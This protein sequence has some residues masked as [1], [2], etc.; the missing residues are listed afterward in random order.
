MICLGA[1]LLSPSLE[2]APVQ[3]DYVAETWQTEA[4]LPHNSVTAVLQTRDGYL[5]LGT[6]NGLARFDGVRFSIFRAVDYAGLRSN[7]ILSLY[8][9]R[10]GVLWVG[11]AEGGL[12]R[13]DDGHF[14]AFSVSDGLSSDT[15]LSIG[16]GRSGELWVGTAS[17]LNRT[18]GARPTGAFQSEA[19]P[20]E[21]VFA[22]RL[23][24]RSPMLFATRKGLYQQRQDRVVP[25]A[26]PGSESRL[27]SI[28][29][30]L[31]EDAERRLWAGGET[32]LLRLDSSGQATTLPR[33]AI[34]DAAVRSLIEG[35]DGRIWMGTSVGDVY[36]VGPKTGPLEASLVGSFGGAIAALCED[37]EGNLWVGAAG[38]GLHRLKPRQVRWTPYPEDFGEPT[39]KTIFENQDGSLWLLTADHR[40]HRCQDTGLVPGEYLPLPDGAVV[41]TVCATTN[42]TLWLGTRSDGLWQWSDGVIRQFTER[43]G[44]SDSQVTVLCGDAA[45][46]LWIGT[47]NGGLNHLAD[48]KVTRFNTPWGFGGASACAL[49]LGPTGSLWIGTTGDGVFELS[50]G[51]FLAYTA[52]NGLPSGHAGALLADAVGALWIGTS[53]GLCRLLDGRITV[54][55]GPNRLTYEAILQLRADAEGHL[56]IG[57]STGLY[58]YRIDQLN[59]YADGKASFVDLVPLGKEDGLPGIQCVSRNQSRSW[60][61]RKGNV[62]FAAAKGIVAVQTAGARRNTAPPPVIVE[63]VLAENEPITIGDPTRIPAGKGSL[64]FQ[65]TALSLSAPGNVAFRYL[66]EGFDEDW[67]EVTATRTAR[68]SKV[69]PGKYRFR[70]VARNN[71]GIWNETGASVALAVIPFWWQSNGFKLGLVGACA[72]ALAGIYRM[73]LSRRKEIE[74]LRVRIASDLHDDVGSSLWSITLLSRMLARHGSLTSEE[75]QDVNEINRISVQTS[76]SI[77]DIIWLINPAFDSLQDFVLRIKDFASVML[78]GVNFRLRCDGIDLTSKLSPDL[79]QNLFFLF[80]E[81]LT[82]VARHAQATEVEVLIERLADDWRFVIHDNGAGFDPRVKTAGNGLK[83][84]RARAMKMSASLAIESQPGQGTTLVLTVAQP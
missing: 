37:N 82:N 26:L 33:S 80:K 77:R 71:D 10:Q 46:G 22:L 75:R 12:T 11:T 17:G 79:R 9:D 27:T 51:R 29:Y 30:C 70:V 5:W 56:W 35:A 63:A 13:I 69:S 58:R 16:E 50:N 57:S 78:R 49:E 19:L 72:T 34:K 1:G 64:Q 45:G 40:L 44:L 6:S 76:N 14:T 23:P 42:N 81:A 2:A 4:G 59:A 68:Y 25:Y 18:S 83:N 24:Q 73:R 66:L 8:E 55:P 52:T 65:F 62:W 48:G 21:P 54:F 38:S 43:D 3:S 39:A 32:G 84:L 7:Q 20:D 41:E 60:P 61:F 15:V 31:H 74:R 47:R 53:G 36:L 67:S 28:F